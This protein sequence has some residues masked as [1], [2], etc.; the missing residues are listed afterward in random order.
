MVRPSWTYPFS[1]LSSFS[2]LYG[3]V[4]APFLLHRCHAAAGARRRDAERVLVLGHQRYTPGPGPLQGYISGG[5]SDC[6]VQLLR[7]TGWLRR[8][9]PRPMDRPLH[10]AKRRRRHRHPAC[11]PIGASAAA[12][13]ASLVAAAAAAA[14]GRAQRQAESPT[15]GGGTAACATAA[16]EQRVLSPTEA[17]DAAATAAAAVGDEAG[18]HVEML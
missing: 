3:A 10:A 14:I 5:S 18:W 15:A 12:D 13:F 1:P 6:R 8:N 17:A 16:T 7:T 2:L 11:A 9:E 4:F